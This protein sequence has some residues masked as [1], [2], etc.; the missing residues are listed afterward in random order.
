[1]DT[2]MT[3]VK[4]M[5][6]KEFVDFGYLHEANRQFFHPLGLALSVVFTGGE[7]TICYLQDA[8]DDPEGIKFAEVDVEKAHRILK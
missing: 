7:P 4:P 1:M 8:R 5:S 2:F 3:S 6:L